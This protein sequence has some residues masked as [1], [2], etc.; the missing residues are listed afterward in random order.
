MAC[1]FIC[2]A[3]GGIRTPLLG[4][5]MTHE[6]PIGGTVDCLHCLDYWLA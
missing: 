6:R 1:L 5:W 4:V 2:G 3:G